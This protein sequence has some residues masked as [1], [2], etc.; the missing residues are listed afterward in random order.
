MV[1]NV[2][3]LRAAT[4]SD[5]PYIDSSLE[6]NGR[7]PWPDLYDPK[8]MAAFDWSA[9][10]LVVQNCKEFDAVRFDAHLLVSECAQNLFES[11]VPGDGEFL[12][13][14]V[15]ARKFLLLVPVRTIDCLD[16]EASC[17]RWFP[18]TRRI[19]SA[20]TYRFRKGD[21]PGFALFRI[22]EHRVPLFTTPEVRDAVLSADL[23][24]F[25]F[26]DAEHP[27]FGVAI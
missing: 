23:I 1:E 19:R 12:Q 18:G 20:E 9:V 7:Y 16:I 10:H 8:E 24:G 2:F 4:G 26:V 6:D 15:N 17:I 25:D 27:P 21:I 13:L 3:L 14:T 5:A 22:P 11:I